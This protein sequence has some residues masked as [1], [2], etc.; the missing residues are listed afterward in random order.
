[1]KRLSESERFD[2]ELRDAIQ[3]I[4]A[5]IPE[6][7]HDR[8]RSHHYLLRRHR[9]RRTLLVGA[10]VVA[11]AVVVTLV[12]TGFGPG[13]QVAF[14]GWSATPTV[15]SPGQVAEANKTCVAFASQSSRS[16]TLQ[17]GTPES[18]W[19]PMVD[20]TRGPYTLVVMAL[21]STTGTDRAACLTGS[22]A[23]ANDPQLTIAAGA[24]TPQPSPDAIGTSGWGRGGTGADTVLLGTV[25]K[26]VTSVTLTLADATK[27][28][29]TVQN[30]I[31]A[32]WWPGTANPT[33]AV[34][35]TG[36]GTATRH[37]FTG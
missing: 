33:S 26:N 18:S 24:A 34:A 27:V 10:P 13:R 11:A 36:T 31:Y 30:G 35:S 29:A 2:F 25:G 6:N 28:D 16:G 12:V 21:T 7:V 5:R 17:F 22:G 8:L 9:A 3:A 23:L 15:P 20:D 4:T 37:S 1:M 19:T 14:A 32:A